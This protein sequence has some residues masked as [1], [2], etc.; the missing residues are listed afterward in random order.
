MNKKV[1]FKQHS[2]VSDTLLYDFDLSIGDTLPPTLINDPS[3]ETNVVSSIDSILIG[4]D[5]HKRFGI[6]LGYDSN[7]V[8]LIEGIGNSFGLMGLLVPPFERGTYLYCVTIDGETVYPDSSYDCPLLLTGIEEDYPS[9][10]IQPKIYPNPST[11][12]VNIEA[13][14]SDQWMTVKLY[15]TLGVLI[16]MDQFRTS[17]LFQYELPEVKGMYLMQLIDGDG[18]EFNQNIVRD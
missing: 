10:R 5:Y 13:T 9:L 14:G 7:Y 16:R 6:S 2:S 3:N 4:N 17:Q 1:Y 15:N 18:F 8:D 12:Y 11:G